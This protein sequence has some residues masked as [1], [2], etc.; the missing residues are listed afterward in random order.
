MNTLTKKE[1]Q[2]QQ[3]KKHGEQLND[4]FHAELDPIVLSKKLH[5]LE[6]KA[7][8][9]AERYCNGDVEG[10]DMEIYAAQILDKVNN[11]LNFRKSEIPVIYNQ[12]PRGYALKIDDEY[13]RAHHLVIY[14]DWG[15][16]GIIAPEF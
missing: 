6:I 3:M 8:F 5:S 14:K 11:I 13:T 1:V 10:D 12:D 9:Q 15:G 16:Y 4:I 7:H 2:Y